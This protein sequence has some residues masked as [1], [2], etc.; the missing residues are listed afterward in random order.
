MMQNNEEDIFYSDDELSDSESYEVKHWLF[1]SL[2]LI[3]TSIRAVHQTWY[4]MTQGD[5]T[6]NESTYFDKT[7][8]KSIKSKFINSPKID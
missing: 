1:L 6:D 8:T 4:K 2:C 7:L 5:S 3:W